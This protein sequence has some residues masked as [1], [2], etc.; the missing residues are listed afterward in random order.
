M[1]AIV[2]GVRKDL[3]DHPFLAL[4]AMATGWIVLLLFLH[5]ATALPKRLRTYAW[6]W[7]RYGDGYGAGVWWPF[8]V[9]A[10]CFLWRVLPFLLGQWRGLT[11]AGMPM[12]MAYLGSVFAV[13][14]VVHGSAIIDWLAQ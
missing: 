12:V 8:Q 1:G 6:N 7:S 4:R 14:A 13:L 9:A 5:W 10:H 11:G 2:T 3:R